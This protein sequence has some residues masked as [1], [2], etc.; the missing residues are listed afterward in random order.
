MKQTQSQLIALWLVEA[1]KKWKITREKANQ[2][3]QRYSLII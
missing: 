1:I 3:L 2:I